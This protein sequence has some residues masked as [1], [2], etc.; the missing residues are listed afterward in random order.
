MAITTGRYFPDVTNLSESCGRVMYKRVGPQ[1]AR[2][3]QAS[4]GGSGKQ[5]QQ[6]NSQNLGSIF[7]TDPSDLLY[8]YNVQ[9]TNLPEV[10][11][12]G[13]GHEEGVVGG[14]GDEAAHP[15]HQVQSTLKSQK[16]K[17]DIPW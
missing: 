3:L 5:W 2:M 8:F 9:S 7:F 13:E 14:P 6:Q 15:H 17:A 10:V 12:D 16:Q 4:W 1:V 11:D